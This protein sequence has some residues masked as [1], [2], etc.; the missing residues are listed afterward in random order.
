MSS[1]GDGDLTQEGQESPVSRVGALSRARGAHHGVGRD[2]D[3]D[4]GNMAPVAEAAGVAGPEGGLGEEEGNQE[5]APARAPEG[6][7]SEEDSDIGPAEEEE[8]E[9]LGLPLVG[10][11]MMVDA[12]QMPMAGFRFMFL[13]LVHS[14]LHRIYYNDHIL[15]RPS[16]GRLVVRHH[17]H[18]PDGG[19]L[20]IE[21]PAVLHVP[22]R[23]PVR[24]PVQEG[25]GPSGLNFLAEAPAVAAAREAE[26][27]EPTAAEEPACGAAEEPTHEAAEEPAH[28]AAEELA[29]GAAEEPTLE[30]AEEP[31]LE[32]AEEPAHEAAEEP[33]CGPA[34]ETTHEATEESACRAAEKPAHEAS[35]EPA[36]GVA[37]E[38]EKE[39]AEGLSEEPTGPATEE[40][41]EE[42]PVLV[43]NTR[44]ITQYEYD[45][46]EELDEDDE[47]DEEKEKEENEKEQD[48]G[49]EEDLD[50]GEGKPTKSRYLCIALSIS[51]LFLAFSCYLQLYFVI[52]SIN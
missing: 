14:L 9:V 32:A 47:G 2:S 7:S 30:A 8:E 20:A 51:R 40:A 46:W 27:Q 26:G 33:A 35:E 34:E 13:D 38:A 37:E 29:C 3:P 12:Q 22:P 43:T 50:P 52:L 11:D 25:E 48:E 36:C 19:D 18:G 21:I 49:P 44:E 1:T 42:S 28:E 6:D 15:I 5:E 39:A 45:H 24:A 16:S 17:P 41:E 31:T 23:P 10:L 4:E